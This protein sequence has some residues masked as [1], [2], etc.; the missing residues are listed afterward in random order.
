MKRIGIC[1]GPS[2]GKTTLARA[3]TVK[4]STSGHNVEHV[5]EYARFH[6][7]E[8][9]KQ[10]TQTPRD[11]L[12]Q[13]I[14]FQNQV[15]WEAAVQDTVEYVISDSPVFMNAVYTYNVID[16]DDYKQRIF[17]YQHYER[18]LEYSRNYY[19][20]IFFL[21]PGDIGFVHDGLRGEDEARAE[22]IGEQIRAFLVFHQMPFYTI[23]GR[24]LDKRIERCLEIIHGNLSI[25]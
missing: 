9:L 25:F 23:T 15:R 3:L 13:V 16:F 18:L 6:I 17:Y 8:Y 4:L 5:T 22:Q 21:P 11:P 10:S 14:I 7:A 24:D 20:Y 1:G 12:H 19:D 2:S